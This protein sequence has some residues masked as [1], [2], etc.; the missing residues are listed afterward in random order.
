MHPDLGSGWSTLSRHELRSNS[1]TS[2]STSV[3]KQ[4][5]VSPLSLFC[6]DD[7]ETNMLFNDLPRDNTATENTKNVAYRG[8][9]WGWPCFILLVVAIYRCLLVKWQ[10]GCMKTAEFCGSVSVKGLFK[11]CHATLIILQLHSWLWNKGS[12]QWFDKTSCLMRLFCSSC[13]H[14]ISKQHVHSFPILIFPNATH[15]HPPP[16][17]SLWR[18]TL[19]L[20]IPL[21]HSGH[22]NSS[23]QPRQTPPHLLCTHPFDCDWQC[24]C[25]IVHSCRLWWRH[26]L[27]HCSY[28]IL[29]RNYRS[30][31]SCTV[32]SASPGMGKCREH[33]TGWHGTMYA[34]GPHWAR[35]STPDC[36][37]P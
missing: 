5:G 20:R 36:R 18:P 37:P 34:D 26:I 33:R 28:C 8:N 23:P 29:H 1:L 30:P 17:L 35:R 4:S 25:S 6:A 13:A 11:P 32:P 31:T 24:L 22:T 9:C 15:C 3:P 27:R 16:V 7:T 2:T 14:S 12:E 19:D 10:E 21:E